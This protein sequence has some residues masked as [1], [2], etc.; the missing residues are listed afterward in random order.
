MQIDKIM[1][2]N[3]YILVPILLVIIAGIIYLIR[4]NKK[5]KKEYEKEI[6]TAETTITEKHDSDHI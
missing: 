2:I 6:N 3:Y 1:E 4:R 5:D